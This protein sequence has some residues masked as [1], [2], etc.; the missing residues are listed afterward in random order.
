MPRS[1]AA[2]LTL[3]AFAFLLLVPAHAQ[4]TPAVPDP[5]PADVESVDAIIAA[6]YDVISGEAGEE[7][8]WDR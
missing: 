6:V 1:I 3:F 8:N 5:D 4:E 7:R 2:C